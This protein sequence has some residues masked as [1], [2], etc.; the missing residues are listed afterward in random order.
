LNIDQQDSGDDTPESWLD[1]HGD[2]LYRYALIQ[3]RDSHLAEE[4]VQDTLLAA[5]QGYQNFRG[6]ASVRT[7]LTGILKHKII[8]HFRREAR[9]TPI[10]EGEEDEINSQFR[11]DGHWQERIT[12]WDNPE[13]ALNNQQFLDILQSC[14]DLLPVMQARLFILRELHGEETKKICKDLTITP[15]NLWT[16]LYRARM[17]LRQCLDRNWVGEARG[18]KC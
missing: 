8:D 1:S 2:V 6:G 4:A 17:G 13:Q 16:M 5:L 11:A 3:L 14:L 18:N 9:E 15:T 10:D 12:H 7:W